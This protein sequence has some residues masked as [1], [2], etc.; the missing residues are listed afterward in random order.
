MPGPGR[1]SW[2]ALTATSAAVVLLVVG[3][4]SR[5]EGAA[6][7]PSRSTAAAE[8]TPTQTPTPTEVALPEQPAAMAEPTTDG[9]I[10]AA[11]Y[12]LELYTYTFA[13]GDVGP[14]NAVTRETC[15]FCA[16]VSADVAEMV[17]QRH[18]VVG[19]TPT[20]NSADATEIAEDRWFS[21]TLQ[22]TQ[23][24]SSR[25]GPDS[26]VISSRPDQEFEVVFALSWEN[27]FRV[28]EMG[29]ELVEEAAQ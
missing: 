7:E 12:V 21:V 19:G 8:E 29:P 20:V 3:G 14:W 11:T 2:R 10:A 6:P 23:A 26:T 9:A 15:Q 1:S 13:S 4:C 5:D 28:D 16:G 27:G 22:V 24:A 17:Q 25:L 18:K